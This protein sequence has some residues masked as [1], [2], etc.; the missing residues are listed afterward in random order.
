[1]SGPLYS[2]LPADD[3]FGSSTLLGRLL[4]YVAGKGLTLYPAQEQGSDRDGDM[5]P[6]C[7]AAL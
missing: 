2:L 5:P 1:M 7:G 4:E 3:D 6:I